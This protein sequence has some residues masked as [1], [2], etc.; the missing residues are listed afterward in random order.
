MTGNDFTQLSEGLSAAP[1]SRQRQRGRPTRE[2]AERRLSD[3]RRCATQI[4]LSE[5]FSRASINQ[6]SAASKIG[7]T[8]IYAHY[9]SKEKFFATVLDDILNNQIH[10]VDDCAETADPEIG[11]INQVHNILAAS[12]DPVYVRLLR[13]FLTE[14]EQFPELFNT[15]MAI[16]EWNMQSLVPHLLA[17][18][19]EGKLAI[20][21]ARTSEMF[22]AVINDQVLMKSAKLDNLHRLSLDDEAIRIVNSV[23]YGALRR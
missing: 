22:A 21:I 11:L 6:I 17:M 10:P 18:E 12:F 7:K 5:G 8:T 14:A 1:T 20:S 16:F 19:R 2:S 13:L 4:I 9:G 3:L 23:L 15:F